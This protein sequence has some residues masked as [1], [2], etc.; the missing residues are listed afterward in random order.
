MC[1]AGSSAIYKDKH[2][3]GTFLLGIYPMIPDRFNSRSVFYIFW[4]QYEPVCSARRA[5]GDYITQFD[6]FAP[7]LESHDDPPY[8]R[9]ALNRSR[10]SNCRYLAITC[11]PGCARYHPSFKFYTVNCPPLIIPRVLL[12]H[13]ETASNTFSKCS[14][15]CV[16]YRN[17]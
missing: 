17:L 3:D 11:V 8:V 1:Q 4:C 6:I 14:A 7:W 12:E 2:F 10:I 9:E 13:T 15:L 5:A 16:L